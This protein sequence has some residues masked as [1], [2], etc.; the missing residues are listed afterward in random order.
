MLVPCARLKTIQRRILSNVFDKKPRHTAADLLAA[1]IHTIATYPSQRTAITIVASFVHCRC[2]GSAE[3]RQG[4]L[5]AL[6]EGLFN[7]RSVDRLEP[8]L[9]LLVL[10]QDGD[11]VAVSDL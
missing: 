5:R 6:P 2:L 7:L 1:G 3:L 4:L 10:D 9:Y 8:N 11:G